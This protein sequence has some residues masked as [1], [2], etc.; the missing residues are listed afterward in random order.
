MYSSHELGKDI[1]LVEMKEVMMFKSQQT[2]L[3]NQNNS[4]RSSLVG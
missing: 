3:L 1:L 4:D 2:T